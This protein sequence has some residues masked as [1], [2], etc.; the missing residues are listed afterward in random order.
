MEQDALLAVDIGDRALAARG[1]GEAGIVGEHARLGVELADVDHVGADRAVQHRIGRCRRR[2]RSRVTVLSVIRSAPPSGRRCGPGFR[3]CPSNAS[4]S[5]I[6]GRR[7]PP[8]QRGAQRL[9]ELAELHAAAL[10]ATS[11]TAASSDVMVPVRNV[12]KRL[13]RRARAGRALRR[14]AAPRRLRRSS[15]GRSA[16]RKRAPSASW[17]R[18]CAR[19]L[20]SGIARTS[21]AVWPSSRPSLRRDQ[22]GQP[23]VVGLADVMAVEV[24]ELLEVEARRRLA[25]MVEVEPL[26]RLLAAD[27]LVVAMAP[28]EP[29]QIIERPPRAGCR[30]RR[31]RRRRR[32][33]RGAC[34][35]WRRR[36]RGSAARGHRSAPASPSRG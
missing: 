27:D 16:N 34:E 29:Q 30:A 33:R 13:V 17:L 23:R 18:S 25:D 14:S 19:A 8:G 36:G 7:R 2:R 24:L 6:P 15:S 11:R 3:P 21:S 31:D 12:R 26:D 1:R 28:A 35:A 32:A 20:S 4:T 22:L 5:K 10:S 9:G